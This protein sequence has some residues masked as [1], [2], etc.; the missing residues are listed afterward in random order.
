MVI[1]CLIVWETTRFFQSTFPILHSHRQY[2]SVPVS[3]ILATL[4]ITCLFDSSHPS[5]CK[6]VSHC[7][8]LSFRFFF[9]YISLVST[10]CILVCTHTHTHVLIGLDWTCYESCHFCCFSLFTSA[11]VQ[12]APVMDVHSTSCGRAPKLALCVRST[13]FMR[14]REPVRE[15]CR[16]GASLSKQICVIADGII[17]LTLLTS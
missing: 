8:F 5:R 1:F 17:S 9:W 2:I 11:S 4:V 15:G 6:V 14:L 13:T 16:W 10:H 12:Q 7:G 3:L